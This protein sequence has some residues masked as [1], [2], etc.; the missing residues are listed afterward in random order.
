MQK[1]APRFIIYRACNRLYYFKFVD[2]NGQ[3]LLKS[4]GYFH[5][6][7]CQSLIILV[8]QNVIFINRYKCL[9]SK[10]GYYFELFT[11]S[12]KSI[13]KSSFFPTHIERALQIK[14]LMHSARF[15]P[16]ESTVSDQI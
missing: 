2:H 5:F 14:S 9:N 4:E 8:K 6:S 12:G 16:V 11:A 7:K 3:T 15:A 10:E 1:D 13:A